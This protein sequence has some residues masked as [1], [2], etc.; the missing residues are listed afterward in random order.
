MNNSFMIQ[1][2]QY[3]EKVEKYK[4]KFEEKSLDYL[5]GE[6]NKYN[7]SFRSNFDFLIGTSA[8]IAALQSVVREKEESINL[9]AKIQ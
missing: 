7:S 3:L 8:K 4:E 5:K 1:L 9:E 6:L 2:D